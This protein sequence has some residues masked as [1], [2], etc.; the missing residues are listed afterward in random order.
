MPEKYD[1]EAVVTRQM[2]KNLQQEGKKHLPRQEKPVEEV[3]CIFEPKKK[4]FEEAPQVKDYR[5]KELVSNALMAQFP[6]KNQDL[7]MIFEKLGVNS[8]TKS[9][10]ST[11]PTKSSKDKEVTMEYLSSVLRGNCDVHKRFPV[12]SIEWGKAMSSRPWRKRTYGFYDIIH[13]RDIASDQKKILSAIVLLTKKCLL[14][15]FQTYDN[16]QIV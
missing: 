15:A 6:A 2:A 13:P 11:K 1:I 4:D 14:P 5:P 7:R 10:K 12:I 16:I 8:N 3:K 9:E